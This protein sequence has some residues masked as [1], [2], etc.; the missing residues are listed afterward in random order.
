MKLELKLFGKVLKEISLEPEREYFLGRSPNCDIVLEE[1]LDLSRRHL[2]IYQTEG[3]KNWN[4][5]S[6]T[7]KSGL[8]FNGEELTEF[9]IQN[10]CFFNLKNYVLSFATEEAEAFENEKSTDKNVATGPSAKEET[11]A[12]SLSFESLKDMGTQIIP[13]ARLLHCLRISIEGEF[14]DYINLNLGKK[15]I[16]GRSEDCDVSINYDLLTRQHLEIEKKE[17]RFYVKD[18]GSTNKTHLN[19]R[20]LSPHKNML[21]NVDDEISVNDLKIVFEIRD[22]DYENK[23]R[24]LPAPPAKNEEEDPFS[25]A[26][27]PKLVLENFV[28]E[29]SE[30]KSSRPDF[31]KKLIFVLTLLILVCLGGW[32]L[33]EDMKN[34]ARSQ[35]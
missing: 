23:I 5:E 19:G 10:N 1:D 15:W 28:E 17:D 29:E 24:N 4:I 33:N 25:G 35:V 18:L 3:S 34:K 26:V 7:E 8:Y 12:D 31:R 16:I 9:E 30:K 13:S 2:R 11:G 6:L 27:A 32:L 14:S 21:L 20:V 22:T